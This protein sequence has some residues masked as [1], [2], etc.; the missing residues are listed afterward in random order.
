[1]ELELTVNYVPFDLGERLDFAKL[2]QALA[3]PWTPI[4]WAAGAMVS[5]FVPRDLSWEEA[6]DFLRTPGRAFLAG[7]PALLV[8]LYCWE[9]AVQRVK[10]I[11]VGRRYRNVDVDV[12]LLTTAAINNLGP[13]TL[14]NSRLL[15]WSGGDRELIVG[16]GALP[17]VRPP[18]HRDF[19]FLQW[20]RGA[21]RRHPQRLLLDRQ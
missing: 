10:I 7:D 13:P 14:Q 9:G 19:L 16:K 3:A 2:V 4:Y 17:G 18:S 5:C 11:E 6:R 8:Y 21:W 1:V 20:T 12:D 15:L